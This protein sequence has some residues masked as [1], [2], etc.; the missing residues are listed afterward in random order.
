MQ[1]KQNVTLNSGHH[2]FVRSKVILKRFFKGCDDEEKSK[3]RLVEINLAE[4]KQEFHQHSYDD[5][6]P[7]DQDER[8][9]AEYLQPTTNGKCLKIEYELEVKLEMEDVYCSYDDPN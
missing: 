8:Q 9:L 1:L 6:K 5:I 7:L 2:K 4:S 3:G